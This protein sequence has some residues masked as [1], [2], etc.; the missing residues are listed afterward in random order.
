MRMENV[1]LMECGVASETR[2]VHQFIT[3]MNSGIMS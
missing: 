2:F 1:V 3:G